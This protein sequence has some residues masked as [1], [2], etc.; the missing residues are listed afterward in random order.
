MK[1]GVLKMEH[2]EKQILI[3]V[4]EIIFSAVVG[5]IAWQ[6][7]GEGIG[8]L[9]SGIILIVLMLVNYLFW[10]HTKQEWIFVVSYGVASLFLT[11]FGV[12]KATSGNQYSGLF[13]IITAVV[14]F[15]IILLTTRRTISSVIS[16]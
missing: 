8:E 10:E 12:Y 7:Y 2:I 14:I 16:D 15:V 9:S 11:V 6:S 4:I 3:V 1:H 13:A 5:Y